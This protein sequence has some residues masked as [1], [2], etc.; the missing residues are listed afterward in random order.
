MFETIR[1]LF[2]Y[3]E[4]A[5]DRVLELL[6]ATPG[7]NPKA[8]GL[9]AHLLL[10]EKIWMLRLQGADTVGIDKSPELTLAECESLAV[11]NQ[12]VYAEFIDSLS[13][14]DLDSVLTYKNL[15]GTEFSTPVK[16]ILMHVALHGTYHRG[17]IATALRLEGQAPVNTDFITFVRAA[18]AG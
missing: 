11:E 17:Q 7:R 6:K 16:D 4:W 18:D 9:L 8:L 2:A 5:V 3:D 14:E 13:E 10:A 12:R 15:K 1:K